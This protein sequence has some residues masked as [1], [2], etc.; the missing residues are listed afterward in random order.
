MEMSTAIAISI[1]GGMALGGVIAI[2]V[3]GRLSRTPEPADPAT[4]VPPGA[5]AVL[6]VL[7]SSVVLF[8]D[9]GAVMKATASANAL[10]VIRSHEMMV[11]EITAMVHKVARDGQVREAE[12]QLESAHG[13]VHIKARVAPVTS[14]FVIALIDDRTREERVIAMRRDFVANVSHEL[15]TP[16]GAMA[17]LADAVAEANDDPEAVAGFAARMKTESSRMTR[18][19]EQIIDLSRLQ[20]DIIDEKPAAVAVSDVLDAAVAAIQNTAEHK[21]VSI[22]VH[23]A[24][25]LTVLGDREQLESAVSNLVENAVAYSPEGG[26]VSLHASVTEDSSAHPRATIAVADAG[27]G[28]DADQTDRIFERFY[29]VDP[30]RNRSTGGT[31]LGLSIVKHIAAGHGGSVSVHSSPGA[32]SRFTLTLPRLE[33]DLD[34]ETPAEKTS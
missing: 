24:P 15:K 2:S 1:M 5:D 25:G 32:G 20:N 22:D 26:T 4:T 28:I 31:G 18:L 14:R 12:L 19:V 29:R 10:G 27:E 34:D 23:A 7:P 21:H 9:A 16:A 6:S 17:V 30:S 3:T 33:T 13:P 8:N 11:P